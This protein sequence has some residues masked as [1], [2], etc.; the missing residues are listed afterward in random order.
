VT[1]SDLNDLARRILDV[2]HVTS[3][4][5][6][7]DMGLVDMEIQVGTIR[8]SKQIPGVQSVTV[9]IELVVHDAERG[10]EVLPETF[11]LLDRKLET[12]KAVDWRS[13]AT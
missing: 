3:I 11:A 2:A 12:L 1:V 9:K 6:H 13:W 5:A 8:M 4:D 10:R 7:P